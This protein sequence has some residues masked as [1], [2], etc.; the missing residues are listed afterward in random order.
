MIGPSAVGVVPKAYWH[1]L[2][3]S[4]KRLLGWG[5]PEPPKLEVSLFATSDLELSEKLQIIQRLEQHQPL[6]LTKIFV[7]KVSFIKTQSL[8]IPAEVK[9]I[10]LVRCRLL[11]V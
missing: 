7:A 9:E 3:E 2:S 8:S 11:G 6:L 4:A 1:L 5:Q 10:A